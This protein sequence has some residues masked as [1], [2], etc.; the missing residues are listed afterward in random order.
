[1]P[2]PSSKPRKPNLISLDKF[3]TVQDQKQRQSIT[4]FSLSLNVAGPIDAKETE[5]RDA[6]VSDGDLVI[7]M[8]HK[9]K[10]VKGV[11]MFRLVSIREWFID[12]LSVHKEAYV[13][14]HVGSLKPWDKPVVITT[15]FGEEQE[16]PFPILDMVPGFD[17]HFDKV[18]VIP[19]P[20]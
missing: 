19:N 12:E 14:I 1:M 11:E 7:G 2:L 15:D 17:L 9:N 5:T 16:N 10:S 20:G 4:T 8:S 6:K 3:S 18:L 13:L